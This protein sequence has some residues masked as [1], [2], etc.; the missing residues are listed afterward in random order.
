MRT[1]IIVDIQNDFLEGGS[2]AVPNGN[3]VIPILNEIQK[4]FDF[5]IFAMKIFG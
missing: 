2:L 4:D 1:L 3:D 5:L